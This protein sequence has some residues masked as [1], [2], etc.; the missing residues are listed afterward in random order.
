MTQSGYNL[1]DLVQEAQTRWLKPAEVLFILQNHTEDQLTHEPARKPTSGSLLLF[2]KRVLRFFRKD[3]HSWRKKKDGRTVGEAH[4]RLKVG[5]VEALNC[6]YAHGEENPLF[7]RRSY[8]MLDP[9]YEHIVLVHYRDISE[10]RQSSGSTSLSPESPSTLSQSP[11]SYTAQHLGSLTQISELNEPYQSPGSIEVSSDAV[12]KTKGMDHLGM[13]ERKG[14]VVVTSEL[15]VTQALRRLEMQLSLT[16]DVVEEIGPFCNENENSNDSEAIISDECRSTASLDELGTLMWRQHSGGNRE[17]NRHPLAQEVMVERK[18]FLSWNEML[19]VNTSSPGA[20]SRE[21]LFPISDENG[22]PHSRHDRLGEQERYQWINFDGY[23]LSKCDDSRTPDSNT[24]LQPSTSYKYL[25]SSENPLTLPASK[26]LSQEIEIFNF[27][28]YS[29]VNNV[30]YSY[31]EYFTTFFDQGQNGMH[32]EADSSLTI[33]QEQKF[34]IREISP[35]WGYA[36]EATKVFI[37]GSFLCDPS[38]GAWTCMFGDIEVPVHMIQQGVISCLA[39]PHLPGKVT[40]CITSGNRESCS[41]VREFEYLVQPSSCAHCGSSQKE[42]TKSPEELLLLVRFVQMLLSDTSMQKGG[43]TESGIDPWGKLRA[44]EDSWGHVIEALLLGSW[45]TSSTTDWL[46]QEL[47]KDKLQQ[48]LSSRLQ[49]ECDESGC[50]LSKKEQGVIHMIAGLGFEWALNLVIN[51]GVS[52]NFRDINGWTAL[53]WAAHF[54]REK[55]VAA[56]IASGAAA[57]AVTDPSSLDPTGK[58]PASIAAKSGHK[59]LAGYLSEVE[60]TSHLSSLKMEEKEISNGSADVE[61]EIALNSIS[62]L[63]RS[64]T[65]N[66]DHNSLKVTLAAVRNAGQAAARIQ[67]A[68]RAHSFRRRQA[69]EVASD[70]SVDDYNILSNDIQGLSVASKLA[71]RNAR[72]YNTAALSIQKKFR[73]WKGR[74]DFLAFRKKVVKIQA[75]VRG[76][77]VRKQ[78]KVICWAVGILEKVVLRWRRK[79]VGLRGYRH[80]SESID[81]SEDEDII[82]VFRKQK[83]EVAIDKA[84]SRVLSMVDSPDARQQYS[85]VL[86]RY[87]QAKAEYEG[88]ESEVTST[89]Q[90]DITYMENE[91][92]YQYI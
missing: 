12:V 13:I 15:E 24:N 54:G 1:H 27:P 60:L 53:H 66:E 4:E 69:K 81:E 41:E 89:S 55:M 82:K 8:W 16:D 7:Q 40:L 74:K 56:L 46:M 76:H 91:D 19:D 14:E 59:G 68:F 38:E 2:N 25:S 87:Q 47:L 67:A 10:G 75:H 70:A 64:F 29:P 6:Y 26:L 50:S 49:G 83:V 18:D 80:E 11:S 61:A 43:D 65:T 28:A 31:S 72:D 17:E 85:R 90:S 71:F 3:G 58:T 35:E 39:P 63:Q 36:S 20:E 78:Y 79:G 22:I 88:P 45:T 51:S 52:T 32:L 48:W 84:F 21:R 86:E 57:G 92:A 23:K 77:Q 30:S 9:T 33:A 73:G 34:T 42:M 5:N 37:V 44:G 62:Q